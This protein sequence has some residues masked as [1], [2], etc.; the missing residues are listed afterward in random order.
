MT[1]GR[2]AFHDTVIGPRLRA[3]RRAIEGVPSGEV[4]NRNILQGLVWDWHTRKFLRP[5]VAA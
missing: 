2:R 4:L 3:L 1:K 5:K